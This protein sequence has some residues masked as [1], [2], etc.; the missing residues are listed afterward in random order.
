MESANWSARRRSFRLFSV[1]Y[2]VGLQLDCFP[3]THI[4]QKHFV[5]F[6]QQEGGL[7]GLNQRFDLHAAEYVD[8]VERL[9]P[10]VEMRRRAEAG[11]QQNF[12]FLALAEGRQR[13]VELLAAKVHVAQNGLEKRFIQIVLSDEIAHGA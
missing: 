8:V 6:D 11:G 5:V 3:D 9:V 4:L 12:L 13:L 1:G 2:A 10:D 7:V